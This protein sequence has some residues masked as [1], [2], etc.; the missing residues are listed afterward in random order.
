MSRWLGWIVMAVGALILAAVL[1]TAGAGIVDAQA[2]RNAVETYGPRGQFVEVNGAQMHVICQGNGEQALVL[3]AGIG[4]GALDWLPVMEN[5]ANEFRVC[6]FDRFGQ[7]WSDPAPMPRT[8]AD[9]ADELHVAVL[10]LGLEHPIVVGHSLGGAVAQIYAGRY[11]VAGLVLVEGLTLDAT[12]EV[13]DRLGTYQHLDWA[14]RLGLLRPMGLL[15]ANSAYPEELRAEMRALRARSL[16]LLQFSAEGALAARNAAEA[17]AAAEQ[18]MDAPMLI[19]AAGNSELPE[20]DVLLESLQDLAERNEDSTF[21]L[22]ADARHYIIASHPQF[23]AD[24]IQEW[25]QASLVE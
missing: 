4:G 5:M 17:L 16:T 15:M 23:V 14:A 24:A 20:S 18:N 12:A 22:V 2:S 13:T 1:V 7:D 21:Q 9:A 10:A 8:F 19:I 11:D 3:Q 25:V 6:A